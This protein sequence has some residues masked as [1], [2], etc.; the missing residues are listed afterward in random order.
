M[1]GA[2]SNQ[3]SLNKLLAPIFRRVRLLLRR[4]VLMGSNSQPRMQTVQVKLTPDLTIEM[5]Y[6]EPYGFT[7][8]PHEGAE[9]IVGN[10]EGKSHPVTLIIADRRYRLKNLEKGEVAMHD[11]QGQV[12]H[13]KR[14]KIL[15][16]TPKDFE[17]RAKN[18]K[19]HATDKYQFDVNGQGQV[20]D[21]EGVTT[22]QNDDVPRPSFDHDV[23]EID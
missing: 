12:I 16:E 23:P 13:F 17:V 21:G 15:I 2:N 1:P 19:F 3:L 7:S 22:Y 18:I 9:P 11:D 8:R 4:G 14:D 6:F 5:E 20:W 10:I